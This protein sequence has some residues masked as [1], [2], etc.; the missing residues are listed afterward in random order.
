MYI[1]SVFEVWRKYNLSYH[2]IIAIR[3]QIFLFSLRFRYG[4]R[5]RTALRLHKWYGLKG[6]ITS[7]KVIMIDEG[8][9]YMRGRNK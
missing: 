4:I 3:G 5:Y 9:L 2:P 6:F 1:K 8:G 7:Y